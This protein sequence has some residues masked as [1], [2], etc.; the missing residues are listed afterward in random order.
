MLPKGLLEE[1]R[2]VMLQYQVALPPGVYVFSPELRLGKMTGKIIEQRSD[3]SGSA[4]CQAEPAVTF[5]FYPLGLLPACLKGAPPSWLS[6]YPF[7]TGLEKLAEA[8]QSF[9]EHLQLHVAKQ[10]ELLKQKEPFRPAKPWPEELGAPVPEE[11][12]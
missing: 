9:L 11:A 1:V 12:P 6:G 3:H 7:L 4:A 5:G 2:A 10:M 8:P